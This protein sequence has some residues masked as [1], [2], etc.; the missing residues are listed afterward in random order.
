MAAQRPMTFTVL[1]DVSGSSIEENC[2]CTN[3]CNLNFTKHSHSPG[4]KKKTQPRKFFVNISTSP[5]TPTVN[6]P[7]YNKNLGLQDF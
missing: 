2:V 7:L 1:L 3:T 5:M 4:K 6:N